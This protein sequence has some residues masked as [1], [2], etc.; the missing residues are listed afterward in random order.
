MRVPGQDSAPSRI[1]VCLRTV[2][3]AP[4]D[5]RL[6][7][8]LFPQ[9]LLVVF[10]CTDHATKVE[11]MVRPS[12]RGTDSRRLNVVRATKAPKLACDTKEWIHSLRH[13]F[14]D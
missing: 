3:H 4:R 11:G 9:G 5:L 14:L 6:L 12:R 7:V 1:S 10:G 2:V 13:L 8:G